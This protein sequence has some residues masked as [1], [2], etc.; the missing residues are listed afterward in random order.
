MKPPVDDGSPRDRRVQATVEHASD[1]DVTGH[2]PFVQAQVR[3][4]RGD[5][6]IGQP[7]DISEPQ[8]T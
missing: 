3:P 4:D 1:L 7:T 5:E 6:L 2:D 8:R